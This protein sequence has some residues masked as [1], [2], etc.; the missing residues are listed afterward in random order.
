MEKILISAC[1]VGDNT[2]YDGG[3][4]YLPVVEKLKEKYELIPFCPEVMGGMSIP[5]E[6][7]EIQGPDVKTKD[8]VSK[9]KE[10]NLGA[11]K[12]L[13]ACRLF[14]IRIAILAESSPSCGV[15][16]VYDGHFNQ[17]KIPGKGITTRLLEEN[18]IA[19]YSS[20]DDLSFLF[21]EPEKKEKEYVSYEE[22][23][24]ELR[25]PKKRRFGDRKPRFVKK[26]E[27]KPAEEN[28]S[29][30]GE[31]KETSEKKDFHKS[32]HKSRFGGKGYS[33]GPRKEGSFHHDHDRHYEHHEGNEEGK[34]RKPYFKKKDGFHDH[35]DGK[36]FS[37]KRSFHGRDDKRSFGGKKDF[38]KGGSFH[39]GGKSFSKGRNFHKDNKKPE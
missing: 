20:L 9:V 4:N 10:Y 8:G 12:A 37:K 34:E 23:D 17:T 6:P 3:N 1:L 26:D 15:R 2:R 13:E 32:F 30:E 22:R 33:R 38:H 21:T 24:F 5:R 14:G 18:G 35:K 36:S 28:V 27:E 25:H 11:K 7:C 39:K 31:T 16:N 19:C 29:S